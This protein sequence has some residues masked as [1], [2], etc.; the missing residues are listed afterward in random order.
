MN[1]NILKEYTK[2]SLSLLVRLYKSVGGWKVA[3]HKQ[4]ESHS[5]LNF[6]LTS[7]C[8]LNGEHKRNPYPHEF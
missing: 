4:Q 6:H 5:F 2:L 1:G 7:Y 3:K 8:G